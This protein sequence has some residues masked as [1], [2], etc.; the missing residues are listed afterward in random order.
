MPSMSATTTSAAAKHNN[1]LTVKQPYDALPGGDDDQPLP[2]AQQ[3]VVAAVSRGDDAVAPTVQEAVAHRTSL[4]QCV[5]W[6]RS[7]RVRGWALPAFLG[8]LGSLVL[9]EMDAVSD[10]LVTIEFYEAGDTGWFEAS[11][12]ILLAS[13]VLATLAL[14]R[15]LCEDVDVR[16][17]AW[18]KTTRSRYCTCLPREPRVLRYFLTF[19][20]VAPVG[21]SGLAPVAVAAITL[22]HGGAAAQELKSGFWMKAFKALELAFEALPQSI[23]QA[24]VAIAYGRLNPSDPERFSRLLCFSISISLLG[25]GATCFSF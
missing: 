15:M 8:L 5:A 22:Y 14:T 18:T 4:S 9:P 21:L 6:V 3:M 1:H 12:T 11:L 25:A 2:A 19:L 24:Y 16:P 7:R 23:L 13:G 10:W 17:N 20:L